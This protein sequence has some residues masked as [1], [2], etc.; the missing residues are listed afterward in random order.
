MQIA[1]MGLTG[2]LDL[3]AIAQRL[4]L[5]F[6]SPK[7]PPAR[8]AAGLVIRSGCVELLSIERGKV[9]TRLRT[10]LDGREPQ[11]LT[12][13]IQRAVSEAGLANKRLA[14]SIPTQDVLFRYFT[15]PNLPRGEWDAAVQFEARKYIP[16]KVDGLIWD[17]YAVPREASAGSGRLGVIFAATQREAFLTILDALSASGI[18]P[19][20]I[21]PRSLSLARL[22]PAPAEGGAQ[23]FTCLVDIEADSAHLAIVRDGMPFFTRDIN[24][25]VRVEEVVPQAPVPQ[26]V[27]DPAAPLEAQGTAQAAPSARGDA[28]GLPDARGQRLLSELSVSLDFFTRENPSARVTRISLFGDEETVRSWCQPLA[29]QLHGSVS[30]G[31]ELLATMGEAALP[32]G[33]ASALGL[34]RAPDQKNLPLDFL[35]RYQAKAPGAGGL[36]FVPALPDLSQ[37]LAVFTQPQTHLALVL[38]ASLLGAVWMWSRGQV[39]QAKRELSRVQSGR[40]DVGWG[41]GDKKHQE[42]AAIQQQA[43]GQFRLLKQWMDERVSVAAKLDALARE[44]PDGVWLTSFTFEGQPDAAGHVRLVFNVSGACFLGGSDKELLA[45]QELTDR[46]KKNAAFHSGFRISQLGQVNSALDQSTR[47]MYR[48]FQLSCNSG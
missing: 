12:R 7:L 4:G 10:L 8:S 45:I 3:T 28:P 41:L 35:K 42:I 20:R 25:M 31:S 34:L 39:A 14:V 38:A 9:A 16:F 30:P 24:W 29:D 22:A 23:E 1:K 46:I 13:A 48:T 17:Y 11:H 44:L 37:L 15:M 6:P 43:Q 32:S 27:I 36:S 40:A 2:G 33:Y 18:E 5:R 19:T 21:E 47:Q 26:A